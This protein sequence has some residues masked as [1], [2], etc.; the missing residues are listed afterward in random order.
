MIFSSSWQHNDSVLIYTSILCRIR[1]AWIYSECSIPSREILISVCGGYGCV[2]IECVCVKIH[3]HTHTQWGFSPQPSLMMLTF[4]SKSD[5][6]RK[7]NRLYISF[8]HTHAHTLIKKQVSLRMCTNSPAVHAI[9]H[10]VHTHNQTWKFTNVLR[11]LLLV[12][13]HEEHTHTHGCVKDAMMS[14]KSWLAA[15]V[16]RHWCSGRKLVCLNR[17][18][19]TPWTQTHYCFP[20]HYWPLLTRLL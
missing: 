11:P 6:G 13:T 5:K 7:G 17:P 2:C 4:K 19:H 15:S 10:F 14:E 12:H 1:E 9:I 20:I 18:S 3:T 8:T 16:I